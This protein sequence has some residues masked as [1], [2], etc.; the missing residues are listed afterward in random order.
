MNQTS[1]K[2][3]H[4]RPVRRDDVAAL[5]N[6]I[7]ATGLFPGEMLNSMVEPFLAGGD[8]RRYLADL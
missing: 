3:E 5:R 6:L 1:Y 8:K 4:I 2:P 7:D